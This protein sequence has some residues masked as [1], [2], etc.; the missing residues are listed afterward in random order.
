MAKWREKESTE[1]KIAKNGEDL[2]LAPLMHRA[3]HMRGE[4]RRKRENRE[5][6]RSKRGRE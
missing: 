2:L 3:S 1:R 6:K 4:E 5:K